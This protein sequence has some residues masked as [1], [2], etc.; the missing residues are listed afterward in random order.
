MEASTVYTRDI[1][2][3]EIVK[4]YGALSVRKIA[5]M[6]GLKKDSIHRALNALKKEISTRNQRFG[7]VRQE[8]SGL[9]A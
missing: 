8:S 3:F 1:M 4:K 9:P 5:D 2:V 6:C 7:K